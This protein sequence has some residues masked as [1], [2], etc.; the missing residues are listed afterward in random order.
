M[1]PSLLLMASSLLN[2]RF[3]R[4]AGV[5]F[6][7]NVRRSRFTVARFSQPLYLCDGVFFRFYYKRRGTNVKRNAAPSSDVPLFSRELSRL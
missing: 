4:S 7:A 2:R 1:N 3:A 5:C 6:A